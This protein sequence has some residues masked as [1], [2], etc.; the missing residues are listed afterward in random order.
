MKSEVTAILL[1]TIQA[2]SPA[3]AARLDLESADKITLESLNLD[4]LDTLKLAMDLE[5]V[6]DMDIEIVNFPATLTLSELA[7]KLSAMKARKVRSALISAT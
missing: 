6:L 1:E 2:L 3:N 5:E 7:E 4:S